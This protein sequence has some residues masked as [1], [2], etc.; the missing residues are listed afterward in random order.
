MKDPVTKD[1]AIEMWTDA[2]ENDCCSCHSHPPCSFCVDGF[3]QSL[4]EYLE[5]RGFGGSVSEL[6]GSIE[7][8]A[9]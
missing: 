1:E 6:D 4:E 7:K 5:D 3:S 2:T 8:E 9:I